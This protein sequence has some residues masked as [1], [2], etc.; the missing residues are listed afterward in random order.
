[1]A[2]TDLSAPRTITLTDVRIATIACS[3]SL[4]SVSTA[5]LRLVEK[6]DHSPRRRLRPRGRRQGR[7]C[8]RRRLPHQ[9]GVGRGGRNRRPSRRVVLG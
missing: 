7:G 3:P 4:G 8:I 6:P 5:G 1:M 9:G 2:V